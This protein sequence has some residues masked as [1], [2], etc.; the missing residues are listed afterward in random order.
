M[1]TTTKAT[2]VQVDSKAIFARLLAAENIVV[3]HDSKAETAYFDTVKR[4]LVLPQWEAMTD[5]LYT[6][7]VGHEVAH[8]LYTPVGDGWVKDLQKISEKDFGVLKGFFNVVEDARIERL[9]K[10]R[11]P[12]LRGSFLHGYDELNKADKFGLKGRDI[13]EMGLIDRINLHYKIGVFIDV[14]FDDDEMDLV[15]EVSQTKTYEDALDLTRR[16]YEFEKAR[17]PKNQPQTQPQPQQGEGE[18]EGGPEE[19]EESE[20]P[21]GGSGEGE[22][23]SEGGSEGSQGDDAEEGQ[24]GKG[25]TS[26]TSQS[27]TSGDGEV[28][29]S[30]TADVLQKSSKEFENQR[31]ADTVYGDLPDFDPSVGVVGSKTIQEWIRVRS[32]G[33]FDSM[34]STLYREF[35]TENAPAI[36]LLYREF[37]QRR[38]ADEQRRTAT[39]DSGSIDVNRLWSYR[40]D[41]NI[42]ATYQTLR[43]G[44][45]HGLI[46]YVDWSGSM[47]GVIFDVARQCLCLAEFCRKANI[48]F[49]VY[50]FTDRGLYDGNLV[51]PWKAAANARNTMFP[52]NF[53][54]LNFLSSRMNARDFVEAAKTFLYA[55]GGCSVTYASRC[56]I[57]TA[58]VLNG[59]PLNAAVVA[60]LTQ[61]P[62]FKAANRLQVVHTVILSDGDATDNLLQKNPDFKS[63]NAN[64][65][66]TN[67]EYVNFSGHAVLRYRGYQTNKFYCYS[68]RA[69]NPLLTL[70]RTINK[71]TNYISFDLNSISQ[72]QGVLTCNGAG[73]E[74][75]ARVK[76]DQYGTLPNY[77]GYSQWFGISVGREDTTDYWGV[78]N[79]A[80]KV[81]AANVRKALSRE[82]GKV[83]ANRQFLARFAELISKEAK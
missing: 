49:E 48:P 1:T 5:N 30:E 14:P 54:L 3:E 36:N 60:S 25:T 63:T 11:Y 39:A 6:M 67:I 34:S 40:V 38:A 24:K 79:G 23:G 47:S 15:R 65:V 17:A 69:T 22:D 68:V 71:G 76:H 55:A 75:V 80:P 41:E 13:S 9:V 77:N 37:Q 73:P 4:R 20:S 81:T 61:V 70:A 28:K 31:G 64:A 16:I 10:T 27:S 29:P 52:A 59:T 35:V 42:F 32:G 26:V 44:Q 51:S 53:R 7:L 50:A 74:T 21:T 43:D 2:R 46:F 83:R 45:N 82:I 56:P 19:G 8:A 58:L 78:L 62:A 33:V 57:P 66:L 18:G 12:G 72:I